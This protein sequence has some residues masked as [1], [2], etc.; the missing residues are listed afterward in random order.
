MSYL[1][2]I[3]G[4]TTVGKSRLAIR[5]A[6]AFDGEIVSADS[7]QV[8]RYMD[9]GTAKPSPEERALIRHHLIDVVNPD[10]EFSLACYQELAYQAIKDVQERKKLAL[11][12]GGSGLYVRAVIDGLRIPQVAP[13]V[14]LRRN[15]G[16]KAK[17]EGYMRLYEELEQSD[18]AAARRI[19]P[20]NVRR[21]IRAIEVFR[22][23][24]LPFSQLQSFSP[25][26]RTLMIGLTT[27]R[28][29][30]YKRIDDR[31]DD[32][33]ECGLAGEVERL[34]ERGYSLDLPSMS[35]LGYK[36]IGL[37]LKGELD[38]SKAVQRIKYETHRFARHQYAWF[39]LKDE[40]IHWFDVRD[41]VEDAVQG[42]IQDSYMN[43]QGLNWQSN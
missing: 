5:L 27:T 4:P 35:G 9:I 25:F 30:L 36:E 24:G 33:I 41:G 38:L 32:M 28:E 21:V 19:D 23:T 14:E 39:R 10:E 6:Q 15:L 1:V 29:D 22:T 34:L 3:M 26:F 43:K 20:R 12:V 11:L 18:P 7:R 37:Y 16:E 42:L 40:R 8:Y 2:A 31:V 17:R 13:D